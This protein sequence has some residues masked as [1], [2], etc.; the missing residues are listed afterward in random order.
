VSWATQLLVLSRSRR[1]PA[2][3][4]TPLRAYRR[5]TLSRVLG[6]IP[7]AAATP[8]LLISAITRGGGFIVIEEE[9]RS[10]PRRGA[11]PGGTSWGKKHRRL[12]SRRFIGFCLSALR[13]WVSVRIPRTPHQ[14]G[15]A[16]ARSS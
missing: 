16:A 5:E 15:A 9:V 2:D 14:A 1:W 4:N 10:L 7:P 11:D 12:P 3:A 6:L 13:E 8:N